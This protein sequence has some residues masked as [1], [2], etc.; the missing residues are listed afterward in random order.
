MEIL[1]QSSEE[2]AI[3]FNLFDNMTQ[4]RYAEALCI[5]LLTQRQEPVKFFPTKAK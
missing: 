5:Y 2:N 4:P 1:S 3:H